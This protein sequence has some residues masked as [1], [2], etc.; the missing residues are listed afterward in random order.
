M[1]SFYVGSKLFGFTQWSM[2]GHMVVWIRWT[3]L[4]NYNTSFQLQNENVARE[5]S[6]IQF[7]QHSRHPDRMAPTRVLRPKTFMFRQA[8]WNEVFKRNKIDVNP[9]PVW[10]FFLYS[11]DSSR[12]TGNPKAVSGTTRAWVA[13]PLGVPDFSLFPYICSRNNVPAQ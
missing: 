5:V 4:H 13:N 6:S 12:G 8:I 11:D 3:I 1:K 9:L 2:G 10:F 7:Y